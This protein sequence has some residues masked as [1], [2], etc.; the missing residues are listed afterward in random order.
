[1]LSMH[2]GNSRM[3]ILTASL[4]L[5]ATASAQ[6]P[7]RQVADPG[8]ITTRQA[9]APAGVQSVFAGRVHAVTFCGPDKVVVALSGTAGEEISVLSATENRVLSHSVR[10]NRSLGLHG[11][12]CMPDGKSL[13]VSDVVRH[14]SDMA[15]ALSIL[16][17]TDLASANEFAAESPADVK[18][19]SLPVDQRPTAS[20]GA[21]AVGGIGTSADGH[22]AAMTV[23][24]ADEVLIADIGSRRIVARV[25]VGIAPSSVVVDREGRSAWASNWG[26]RLAKQGERTAPTGTGEREDKV[27]IDGRGIASSGTLSRIDLTA[28]RVTDEV[29]VGLHPSSLAWDEAHSRLYVVNGNSDS[30]SVVDTH[31]RKVVATWNIQ[32]FAIRIQGAAPTAAALSPDAKRLYVTCGG[33]NAIAVMDTVS[34]KVDGLIP[35]GWYP[36]HIAL[37]PDGKVVAVA[38]LLGVGSGSAMSDDTLQYFRTELPGLRTGMDRRY[39]HS[40]RGTVH[41]IPVPEPGQLEA[42]TRATAENTHLRLQAEQVAPPNP[43]ARA[44]P[45]PE[46]AGEPSLIEHV[47]YI[48][49]E[50]RSYDQLFG[51]LERGNGDPSLLLYG[52][53]STPNHRA[54]AR[55]FVVLDNFY[56]TGGNSGDG[57]QWVTQAA[58]SD[59]AMWPGYAG[60]SYPFDGNDPLAYAGG[61]FLWDAALKAGRT[62]ADFGEFVPSGQ[63]REIRE[64]PKL[65]P[66][67]VR[68]SLLREWRDGDRFLGRFQVKSPIPPLDAH[69]VRDYPSYGGTS[70]DVVRARI[71]LRHLKDWEQSGTMP[72]LTFIQLAADH[73]SGTSPGWNTP[74]ACLA[75][76]DLALGQMVEGLTH[77]KFWPHMAIYVV[78]D[79]A[80]GGV[81]HVDGHRTVA[82]AVSPYIRRHSVDSTFYSHPSISR[83]VELQLGLGNLSVFDLIA[84]DM[85]NSFSE[86]PDLTPYTAVTPQQSIFELNP[87]LAALQGQARRD[88]LASSKM[89]WAVPDAAPAKQLLEILWRDAKGYDRPPAEQRSAVFVPYALPDGDDDDAKPRSLPRRL[90]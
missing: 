19:S 28:K 37:S 89:N 36:A 15:A 66:G 10:P 3:R 77:S 79:D 34:G 6:S 24:G 75:D 27:L 52:E 35:T 82:L 31:A 8:I 55:Q 38:T 85:R 63:Y 16:S 40:Y 39:V 76:N 12:I 20:S 51:D 30:V 5:A 67:V 13:L 47:V 73:T 29:A 81:D 58:E 64:N 50:N 4:L 9:I 65:D 45:V 71:F 78:E 86:T 80:Q 72:S 7:A 68:A 74:K 61:G 41:L 59:Y 17:A 2:S 44:L 57:H 1:M 90:K 43:R 26:G 18:S 21:G 33:I 11:A 70:P 32:P 69:L 42:Y 49:K 87:K 48:V 14:G 60:R 46:R 84:N 88:A 83:T 54:M 56:A 25:P 23:I 53:E 62:F 22:I